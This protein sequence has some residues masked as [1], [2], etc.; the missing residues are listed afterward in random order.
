MMQMIR[1]F[2]LVEGASFIA[3]ALTHFGVLTFAR[4]YEHL[5]AGR[6]ESVI[7]MVLLAGLVWTVVRP[8]STRTIGLAT[9]GFAL[10]GTF[11]GLFTIAIGVG[12]QTAADLTYH[13]AIVL[14][15]VVGLV[16]TARAR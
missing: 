9:Q 7:G 3:A 5:K 15:L 4:G 10:L 1:L 11:V 12:P 8:A 2:M 14:V 16:V 6:A 13:A